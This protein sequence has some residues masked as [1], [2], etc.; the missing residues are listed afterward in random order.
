MHARTLTEP[1]WTP[2][3]HQIPPPGDW[4]GWLLLAGRGAGKT[5]ACA[6]YVHDHVYGPPCL[7]GPVPH[8]VGIIA[9][10]LGDAAT[11]C[12][13][14]PSGL[15]AHSPEA[16]MVTV[17][18]GT[19]VRWPNGSEAK[20]FG[21]NTEPDTERLRSGGNRCLAWLEEMAAWR[22]L[23]SA[24]AQMRFG[25]RT[26]PRP[27]WV[28]STTPKPRPLIKKLASGGV[29]NVVLAR[30][31]MDDNP[32]LQ[33]HVRQALLDEYEGTD[34]GRQ[35]LQGEILDEDSNA[36]W[37]RASLEGSRL[38]VPDTKLV[39]ISVGV[40]PSGGAGE[41]GIVVVGKGMIE[42]VRFREVE[43]QQREVKTPLPHGYVLGDRTVH[44][45]PEGWGKAAVDAAVEF[46]AD[47]ICVEV[48]FGGDMAV[49]TIRAAADLMGVNIPI[50]QVRATRGKQV[51]AQPVAALTAQGRWH[52]IGVHPELEDQ[53]CTWYPE[54][55]WSPDRLDASVWPGHDLRIVKMTMTGQQHS[56]GMSAMARQVG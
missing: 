45:K 40:D 24:W 55:D 41:Q 37:T 4:Y 26:G 47:D 11:S 56:G 53:Y 22:Y 49:S 6:K 17:A 52:M 43:G 18:G 1:R 23:D 51:R 30:A 3:P 31:S 50:K 54:L 42:H 16:R 36:L 48:N 13:T 5:D 29:P 32:H 19:V 46:D 33:E 34:L 9:P 44:L 21:A 35:E 2:L 10:T 14:G 20:L 12:V 7:P 8:W 28:A 25:L 27:H 15:M 38:L 39:R